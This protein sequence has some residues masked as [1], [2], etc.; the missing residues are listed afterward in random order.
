VKLCLHKTTKRKHFKKNEQNSIFQKIDKKKEVFFGQ[1]SISVNLFSLFFKIDL[2][3]RKKTQI[4]MLLG[5]IKNLA[6]I[7]DHAY[8]VKK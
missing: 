4:N 2:F 5:G 7:K 3:H 6:K 8:F 1:N